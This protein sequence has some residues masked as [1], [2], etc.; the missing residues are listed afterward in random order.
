VQP[1][2]H[3][4]VLTKHPEPIFILVIAV[5]RI[6]HIRLL[7]FQLDKTFMV[8]IRVLSQLK[9]RLNAGCFMAG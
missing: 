9:G 8:L 1:K 7:I 3:A 2:I 4:A 5:C 6:Q